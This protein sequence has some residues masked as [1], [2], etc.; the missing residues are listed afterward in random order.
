MRNSV[1]TVLAAAVCCLVT[2]L[3]CQAEESPALLTPATLDALL[4]EGLDPVDDARPLDDTQFLRRL[5]LDLIGRQPTREELAAFDADD[6]PDRRSRW[7]E[8]LLASEEFGRHWATYWSDTISYRVPPPELTFLN[9]DPF[10]EWLAER[11]NANRPW[12]E[13]AGEILTAVG[14]IKEQPAATFVGYHQ[15]NP[16]KLAA[17]TSRIFLGLQIQCAQCHDHPYEEWKREQFHHL[18]AYFARVEAKL[19]WR[20]GPETV[21]KVKEKGEYR[22]PDP[23]DPRKKGTT[24]VPAVLTGEALELETSDEARRQ[25]LAAWVTQRDN[26]WFSRAY[27]NRIWARL[28]GRGFCEPVDNL[29]GSGELNLPEIHDAVAAS[30]TASG[31]DVKG[32]VRLIVRTEA[33]QRERPLAGLPGTSEVDVVEK[34]LGDQVFQSLVTALNLPN[35]TPEGME[36]T[37][38]I[39]FPPPPK[40]TRDL[41][42]DA[43]GYDPSLCPEE[44]ARTMMQA[45]FLMNNVQVQSQIDATPGSGTLLAELLESES[46]D[47]AV[48]NVLFERVLARRPTEREW[49]IADEHLRRIESRGAA[50]EDILWSLVNSTEFTTRR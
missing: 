40:S 42:V 18:A 41:V 45:M 46:D 15:A 22:M 47:R 34:L 25:Q 23:V 9:Y 48:V 38:A 20:D 11:I 3:L 19:P 5:S 50:F 7:I 12:D 32:L 29:G 1:R 8:R 14:K 2:P 10:K 37:D 4:V 13:V 26:P 28:M 43:F 35:I 39:R 31:Y 27:V 44:V 16:V 21:V 24:M 33:Y 6:E 49:E 36:P 17:E 30:F